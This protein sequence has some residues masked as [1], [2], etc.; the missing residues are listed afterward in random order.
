VDE[1]VADLLSVLDATET[2]RATLFGNA[3]TGPACIA[4]AALHPDRVDG[5]ILLGTYAKGGWDEDY[6]IGWTTEEWEEFR[7]R[8]KEGWGTSDFVET[9]APSLAHDEA[10]RQWY[11]TLGRLG[12]ALEQSCSWVRCRALLTCARCSPGSPFRRS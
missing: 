1:R 6:P 11:A 5:L 3:D 9:V 10:F 7:T 8:V 12:R 4:V 2:E